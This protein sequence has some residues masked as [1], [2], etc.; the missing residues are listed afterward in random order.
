MSGLCRNAVSSASSSVMG[1]L[2]ASGAGAG[3]T[4]TVRV[5]IGPGVLTVSA[6]GGIARSGDGAGSAAGGD[7][8]GFTSAASGGPGSFGHTAASP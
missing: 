3:V 6:F 4:S 2:R 8:T 7:S 5:S 1:R